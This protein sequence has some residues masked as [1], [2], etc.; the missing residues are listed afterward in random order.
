MP[1][2]LFTVPQNQSPVRVVPWDYINQILV[3]IKDFGAVGDGETD[4]T[5]AIQSAIDYAISIKGYVFCPPGIYLISCDWGGDWA[6]LMGYCDYTRTTGLTS[7]T[8]PVTPLQITPAFQSMAIVGSYAPADRPSNLETF[9]QHGTVFKFAG[10]AN[11][12]AIKT[13]FWQNNLRLL[14]LSI[15][16]TSFEDESNAIYYDVGST[17][18]EL[19]NIYI[20]HFGC[21]LNIGPNYL[22]Y[23]DVHADFVHCHKLSVNYCDYGVKINNVNAY[24]VKLLNCKIQARICVSSPR[25]SI[26]TPTAANSPRSSIDNTFLY[27]NSGI[28][29]KL[30]RA[31]VTSVLGQ[32]VTIQP[33]TDDGKIW[34]VVKS[35][36]L[37]SFGV[38]TTVTDDAVVGDITTEMYCHIDKNCNSG[39]AA[40]IWDRSILNRVT[41]VNGNEITLD[42]TIDATDLAG[43][44]AD[45]FMPAVGFQ[46]DAVSFYN[47]Q[48]EAPA[49]QD[50]GYGGIAVE[51]RGW[52]NTNALNGCT[53]NIFQTEVDF[54]SKGSY[55]N[56]KKVLFYSKRIFAFHGSPFLIRDCTLN[57]LE[58][59]WEV[60]GAAG[61]KFVGNDHYCTPRILDHNGVLANGVQMEDEHYFAK[62]RVSSDVASTEEFRS[63]IGSFGPARYE[64][65]SGILKRPITMAT[66]APTSG[67]T[68]EIYYLTESPEIFYRVGQTGGLPGDYNTTAI[69]AITA[70]GTI[71]QSV[72]TVS[73][74]TGLWIG[75]VVT[76]NG[77]LNRVEDIFR[78]PN[79]GVETIYLFVALT[80]SFAGAPI[81][82]PSFTLESSVQIGRAS[83]STVQAAFIGG[84]GGGM[85][86]Q[87]AA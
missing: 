77:Q 14:N 1:Q 81:A 72:V 73:D 35:I 70:T 86:Q 19:D 62:C 56:R 3:N 69:G 7:A 87:Q 50:G 83:S 42:G 59:N 27:P 32:V 74:S 37:S 49:D 24:L 57:V 53:V 2:K 21:A 39:G 76:I 31:Q 8:N 38:T 22:D 41:A 66:T 13:G 40:R 10:G 33:F 16:G 20:Q 58:N 25:S 63:N 6:L 84:A 78:N 45:F 36:N 18:L 71:G 61:V 68:G 47:A 51:F 9:T 26:T 85:M 29:G 12:S 80:S 64:I 67:I 60:E 65:V 4:D 15:I 44:V 28:R 34:K 52:K 46:G 54:G 82:A 43:Q 5:F 75:R 23:A 17:D 55:F 79:T 48:I 11:K 30:I